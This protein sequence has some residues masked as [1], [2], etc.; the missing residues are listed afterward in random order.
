ML[1]CKQKPDV[2]EQSSNTI[3]YDIRRNN[4]RNIVFRF[5]KYLTI[6]LKKKILNRVC[7]SVYLSYS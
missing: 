1:K 3:G 6:L 7:K 4:I 5:Y 2:L